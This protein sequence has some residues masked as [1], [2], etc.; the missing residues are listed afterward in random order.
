MDLI[1]AAG[2]APLIVQFAMDLK[3][4]VIVLLAPI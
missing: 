4:V 3:P 1:G 2:H